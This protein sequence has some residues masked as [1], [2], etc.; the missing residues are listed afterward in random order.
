MNVHIEALTFLTKSLQHY[1]DAES[2]DELQRQII[3]EQVP[4]EQV[5]ELANIH[6]LTPALWN[7]LKTKKLNN[8]LPDDIQN[9]LT[10]LHQMSV[11]RNEHLTAQLLEAVA[12]LNSAGV[13]PILMKGAKYLVSDVYGDPGSRVMSDIDLLVREDETEHC[14]DVLAEIGYNPGEDI[15]NDY[16]DKH[17][18]CPPLFRPGDYGTLEIHRYV[19]QQPFESVLPTSIAY[20]DAEPFSH[21]TLHMKVFSPTHRAL[22][23]I[24]HSFLVDLAY[25]NGIF[26]LRSMHELHIECA[27]KEHEIDWIFIAKQL[28]GKQ[29]SNALEAYIYLANR[30]YGSPIPKNI[31]RGVL[32]YLYFTRC[33]GQLKWHWMNAWG[34]RYGRFS[35]D[36][37]RRIQGAG[38]KPGSA[39]KMRLKRLNRKISSLTTRIKR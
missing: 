24:L 37:A 2:V 32:A 21:P 27:K 23:N 3:A 36:N 17:H 13:T 12:T 31:Q 38:Y 34:L 39:S 7:A 9:Y 18:H 26:P 16:H 30:L 19:T 4:W 15:H 25:V 20:S 1:L 22:H 10:E 28:N 5:I 35:T 29:R 33:C 14:M 8:V 11:N 6:L